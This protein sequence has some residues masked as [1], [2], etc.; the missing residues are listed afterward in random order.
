MI[1]EGGSINEEEW[2]LDDWGKVKVWGQ[3]N[4]PKDVQS[5]G[6]GNA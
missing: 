3:K 4:T 1:N 2:G 5:L 6:V